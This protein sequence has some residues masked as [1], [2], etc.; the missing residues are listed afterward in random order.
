MIIMFRGLRV[1]CDFVEAW[2]AASTHVDRRSETLEC[3]HDRQIHFLM[4]D[5]STGDDGVGEFTQASCVL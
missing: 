2:R 1:L 5:A 4:E 3:N